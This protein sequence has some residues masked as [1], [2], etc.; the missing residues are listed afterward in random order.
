MTFGKF[1]GQ[2]IEELPE[3]YLTWCYDNLNF[4]SAEL[5]SA[6]AKRLGRKETEAA[7]K[8]SRIDELNFLNRQ[9]NRELTVLKD[10]Y[11]SLKGAYEVLKMANPEAA[12]SELDNRFMAVLNAHK[13]RYKRFDV[14]RFVLDIGD[15]AETKQKVIDEGVVKFNAI[16]RK[17]RTKE[18]MAEYARLNA[19]PKTEALAA[20]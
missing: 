19:K 17:R 12:M 15:D 13:E 14:G 9:L 18:Y 16:F 2:P 7:L 8:A 5:R 3:E 11:A 1:S 10:R 20:F 6:I 4:R